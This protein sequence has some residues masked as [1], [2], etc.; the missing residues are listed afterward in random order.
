MSSS[1]SLPFLDILAEQNGHEPSTMGAGELGLVI[2]LRNS[3]DEL[4][5]SWNAIGPED[6]DPRE[7]VRSLEA[8]V[9]ELEGAKVP[10][11]LCPALRD[12][13]TCQLPVGHVGDQHFDGTAGVWRTKHKHYRTLEEVDERFLETADRDALLGYIEGLQDCIRASNEEGCE[14]DPRE[15][16]YVC[17]CGANNRGKNDRG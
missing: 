9:A 7:Y 14:C 3:H 12:G 2:S 15:K 13:K 8:R 4:V 16:N 11:E 10:R 17:T 1:K 6:V 5:R